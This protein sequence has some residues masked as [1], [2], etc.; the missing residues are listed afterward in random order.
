MVDI[1]LIVGVVIG[2][3]YIIGNGVYLFVLFA[4]QSQT[5]VLGI[6]AIS[7]KDE[8]KVRATLIE[9]R[10]FYDTRWLVDVTT[11]EDSFSCE[12]T[13]QEDESSES[14]EAAVREAVK[15]NARKETVLALDERHKIYYD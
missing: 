7:D 1:L 13:R 12:I 8:I 11:P 10:H 3:L 6:S 4:N 5:D 15:I 2:A 9:K 14:L